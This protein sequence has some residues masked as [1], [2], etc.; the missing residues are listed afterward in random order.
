MSAPSAHAAGHSAE[1]MTW[2]AISSVFTAMKSSVHHSFPLPR[3]PSVLRVPPVDGATLAAKDGL[4]EART[5]TAMTSSNYEDPP[6]FSLYP[7]CVRL[8]FN[9]YLH[10][11]NTNFRHLLATLSVLVG[12]FYMSDLFA[13]FGA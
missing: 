11:T 4:A 7:L 8:C 10:L 6:V 3:R 9:P 1:S 12:D 13:S 2:V 5:V